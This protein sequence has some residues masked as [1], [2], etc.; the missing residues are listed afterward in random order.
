MPLYVVTSFD[1]RREV[2][3]PLETTI[4]TKKSSKTLPLYK[5]GTGLSIFAIEQNKR[6]IK[7]LIDNYQKE[8]YINN[9]KAHLSGFGLNNTSAKIYN[10]FPLAEK[11][12]KELLKSSIKEMMTS[13]NESWRK[14]SSKASNV[15]EYLERRGIKLGTRSMYP[16]Y[17][18]TTYSGRSR[19]RGFNIQGATENDPIN[20]MDENKNIFIHLDWVAADLR[21][22]SLLCKDERL[23]DSYRVSDP[24]T[25]QNSSGTIKRD[26]LASLYSM[27]YD[28]SV[29]SAFP[30]IKPWM[31]E[32]IDLGKTQ[33]YFK[34]I[35]GRK[36][37]FD[38]KYE[39]KERTLKS[40]FNAMIQG[41]IA[42]AMQAC[43]YKIYE[44]FPD[45]IL[46]EIHDSLVVVTTEH[47]LKKKIDKL[48]NIMMHPLGREINFPV[49]VSVGKKWK[50]WKPLRIYRN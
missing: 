36:F 27:N 4:I 21:I 45:D 29:F 13:E 2:P 18:Q 10:F 17:D 39:G 6:S 25:Y 7:E 35:L 31:R 47:K 14:I 11:E 19:T 43:I 24:Y 9:Y 23:N 38:I 15:Y 40:A 49:R 50:Q 44:I 42:H 8:I 46:A 30:R 32:C 48:S 3:L 12:H 26:T 1:H 33:G 28:S 16:R 41:S 22:V 5:K 37:Y 20:S 34:S